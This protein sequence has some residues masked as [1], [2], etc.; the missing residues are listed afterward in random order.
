MMSLAAPGAIGSLAR[1]SCDFSDTA[2][3]PDKVD[4]PF[5]AD[6]DKPA[7]SIREKLDAHVGRHPG[8]DLAFVVDNAD[9][10]MA[11]SQQDMPQTCAFKLHPDSLPR[12]APAGALHHS[13]G[14]FTNW[15]VWA[16]PLRVVHQSFAQRGP[17]VGSDII[18]HCPSH[19]SR[20][21]RGS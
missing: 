15:P 20:R 19:N 11:R 10:G 18:K 21:V 3:R 9:L 4:A 8:R 16:V 14:G 13:D 12:L 17:N 1:V 6:A 7:R 2:P 5:R